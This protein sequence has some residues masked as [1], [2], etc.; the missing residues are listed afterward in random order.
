MPRARKYAVV[1]PPTHTFNELFPRC[2]QTLSKQLAQHR[3]LPGHFL[4]S[5]QNLCRSWWRR[6]TRGRRVLRL[7]KTLKQQNL[8][9][10]STFSQLIILFVS[11]VVVQQL[12]IV[13]RQWL[14]M[15]FIPCSSRGPRDDFL[16]NTHLSRFYSAD[17]FPLPGPQR[18]LRRSASSTH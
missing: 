9:L 4:T 12:C 3:N 15:L 8:R 17:L 18:D 14:K 13:V 6:R 2:L 11:L 5:C 16:G 1:S 7:E 10:K